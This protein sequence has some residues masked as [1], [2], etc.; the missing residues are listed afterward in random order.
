MQSQVCRL[1]TLVLKQAN[2]E[3]PSDAIRESDLRARA[4]GGRFWRPCLA[5]LS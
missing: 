4:A 5:N 2:A 1:V 3:G